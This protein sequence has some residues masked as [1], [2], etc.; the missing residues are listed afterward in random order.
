MDQMSGDRGARKE[1]NEGSRGRK[2]GRRGR[3]M[4][5]EGGK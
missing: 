2:E 3:K 5:E 1:R 4:R